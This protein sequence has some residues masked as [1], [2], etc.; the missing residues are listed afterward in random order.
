MNIQFP[1]AATI[2]LLGSAPAASMVNKTVNIREAGIV[3]LRGSEQP[4]HGSGRI[5]RQPRPAGSFSAIEADDAINVEVVI[6]QPTSIEA[7]AD[8]NLIQRIT[9]RIEDGT[10][11]LGARGSYAAA[12]A[13]VVRE[14]MPKL[15]RVDLHA[16]SNAVIRGLRGGRLILS[17][18]GSGEFF[19]DGWVDVIEAEFSGSGGADLAELKADDVSIAINGSG[20][21][22]VHANR[23]I[24]AAVNGS[25]R[26]T[27]RGD[28]SQVRESV[29]GSGSIGRT[30]N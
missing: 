8:D 16:S 9:T 19:A 28:P 2:L 22:R 11:K 3:V 23:A 5:I 29:D 7:V 25:G 18:N 21:A 13:P 17:S 4:T 14:T 12:A 24:S 27:Y 1:I 30:R 10:L 15:R 20:R 6:G 26:L